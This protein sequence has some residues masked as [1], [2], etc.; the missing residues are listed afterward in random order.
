MELG[1]FV[2]VI[3]AQALSEEPISIVQAILQLFYRESLIQTSR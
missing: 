2:K 1:Q 3:S